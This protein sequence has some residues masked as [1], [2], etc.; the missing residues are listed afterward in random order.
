MRAVLTE[1]ARD[2]L[3]WN[4]SGMGVMEMSH[5]ARDTHP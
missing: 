5:R 3:D 4:G 1:A 2:M